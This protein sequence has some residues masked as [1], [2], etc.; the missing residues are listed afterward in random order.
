MSENPK[1]NRF[2]MQEEDVILLGRHEP[3]KSDLAEA[4]EVFNRILGGLSKEPPHMSRRN[5]GT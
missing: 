3:S 4:D 5:R 1:K 2:I